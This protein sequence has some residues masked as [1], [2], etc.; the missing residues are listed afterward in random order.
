[1]EAGY[2]VQIWA[3]DLPPRTTSNIAAAIWHPFRAFPIER[4][5]AWGQRSLEVF[6]DLVS[7]PESGVTISEG[8]EIYKGK[9]GEP[10]WRDA[11]RRFRFAEPGELPSGY[12][13]G[14]FF[15][16]VVVETGIYLP[17]LMRR[18]EGL[19]GRIVQRE[20]HSLS[21]VLSEAQ[22]VANC[23]G[24]GTLSF[25]HD[26][27]LAPIRGQI[28]R[29][30][31][32]EPKRIWLDDE[33]PDENGGITYVVPRSNDCILGG[34]TQAGN[35]SL[36]PDEATALGIFERC[37]RLV[38]EVREAQVL[39]HLVGLRP[40]RTSVRLEAEEQEGG[41]VVQNYGH[42]GAGITLSWGCAEEVVR[43]LSA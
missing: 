13:S 21:E 41:V 4:V 20:I 14:Y 30:S 22:V 32:I 26:E 17:Y 15:E 7:E 37:A 36:Q 29:V 18:F 19:G 10:W 35:W 33:K 40:G 6:Y 39:E 27:E 42:G 28:I 8:F 43:L 5:L 9:V 24:L 38:P 12:G 23:A 16:T 34:V 3:R 11:V 31:K 1:M 2:D 25:L